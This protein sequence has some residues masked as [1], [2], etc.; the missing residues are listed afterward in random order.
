MPGRGLDNEEKNFQD[1]L[2]FYIAV[3]NYLIESGY[4][5]VYISPEIDTE[6][7]IFDEGLH[8]LF[9]DVEIVEAISKLKTL[10]YW[11]VFYDNY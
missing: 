6:I 3:R 1:N 10:E 7:I 11:K 8:V 9:C 2:E 5:I 4:D